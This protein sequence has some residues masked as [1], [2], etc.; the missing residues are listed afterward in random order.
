[1]S[2]TQAHSKD[3]PTR[4]GEQQLVTAAKVIVQEGGALR[5]PRDQLEEEEVL[6][7]IGNCYSCLVARAEA[8]RWS[9]LAKIWAVR[10]ADVAPG[11][12][13]AAPWRNLRAIIP[14]AS[15]KSCHNCWRV[16]VVEESQKPP[17]ERESVSGLR[18]KSGDDMSNGA[19]CDLPKPR[20]QPA[21]ISNS[22]EG[23]SANRV[24]VATDLRK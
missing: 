23:T 6:A 22:E 3:T 18:A 16:A 2:R 15:C 8:N 11:A 21:K 5:T 20:A 13:R 24:E 7:A 14:H 9:S 10:L 4:E 17:R 19:C 12:W 1:M